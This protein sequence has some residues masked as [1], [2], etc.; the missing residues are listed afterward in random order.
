[1]NIPCT[2]DISI[3]NNKRIVDGIIR[4]FGKSRDI[5]EIGSVVFCQDDDGTKFKITQFNGNRKIVSVG[6]VENG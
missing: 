3:P 6:P 5:N 4:D 1:M 2:I